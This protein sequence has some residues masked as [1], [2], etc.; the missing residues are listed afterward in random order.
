MFPRNS[1]SNTDSYEPLIEH[2]IGGLITLREFENRYLRLF[3]E[4]TRNFSDAEYDLLNR[5]FTDLDAYCPHPGLRGED[6]ISDEQL[7]TRARSALQRLRAH[8]RDQQ[9]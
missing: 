2:F 3:K 9:T 6:D 8:A 5:L 7:V 4:D 1:R